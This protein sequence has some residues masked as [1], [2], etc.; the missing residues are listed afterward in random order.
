MKRNH[1]IAGWLLMFVITSGL[2]EVFLPPL[3]LAATTA[4]DQTPP[5]PSSNLIFYDPD[6]QE[7]I[8][9]TYLG[10]AEEMPDPG[11]PAVVLQKYLEQNAHG[12]DQQIVRDEQRLKS[13]VAAWRDLVQQYPRSRHA[14]AALAKHLRMKGIYSRDEALKREAADTYLRA[15]DAGLQHGRVRYTRQLS[16]IL[17]EVGDKK[18]LHQGFQRLL[19]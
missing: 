11:E 2:T 3:Q 1:G 15:V 17:V 18:G 5:P 8:E 14:L 12:Y 19:A 7:L 9:T 13:E 6:V 10:H 4:T 16:E